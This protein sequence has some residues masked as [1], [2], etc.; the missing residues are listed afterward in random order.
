[1]KPHQCA[2]CH[3][4]YETEY[5]LRSHERWCYPIREIPI[6]SEYT[7][8]RVEKKIMLADTRWCR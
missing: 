1:M 8:R 7:K 5:G 2:R 4:R 3:R 6:R